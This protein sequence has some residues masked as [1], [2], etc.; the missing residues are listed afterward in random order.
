[1]R[2][3]RFDRLVLVIAVV[4]LVAG[5]GD[6]GDG[7]ANI[8]APSTDAPAPTAPPTTVASTTTAAPSTTLAP[9]TTV[10][11]TTTTTAAPTTTIPKLPLVEE[12]IGGT[13]S[14]DGW[15]V[16]PGLYTSNE[17]GVPIRLDITEARSPSSTTF[18]P[19]SSA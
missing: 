13:P 11:P 1:M 19:S 12:A 5:C 8:A 18:R 10:L 7:E 16:E 6:G 2:P 9:T 17:V 14:G 4:L 3:F 15:L